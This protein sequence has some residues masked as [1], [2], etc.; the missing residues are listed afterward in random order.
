[1]NDPRKRETMVPCPRCE[2][3]GLTGL[4]EERGGRPSCPL[5]HG[6][7]LVTPLVAAYWRERH[8]LM[9]RPR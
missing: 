2:E 1:V 3:L 8:P 4:T 5:C 9:G 7:G 6:V